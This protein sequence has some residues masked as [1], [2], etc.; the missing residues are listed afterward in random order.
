MTMTAVLLVVVYG[1]FGLCIPTGLLCILQYILSKM[2]SPWPGRVLP[3]LSGLF[4]LM[5]AGVLLCNMAY[6]GGGGVRILLTAVLAILLLNI[7]TVLYLVIYRNTRRK[8][9]T[10]KD[11]DKMSI[12]DLE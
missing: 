11:M 4:S 7:P 1:L 5:M 9:R 3:I 2:E 10:Q 12:Q 6:A 8:Y